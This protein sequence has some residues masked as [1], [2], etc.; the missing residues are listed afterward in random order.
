M[1][2][3]APFVFRGLGFLANLEGIQMVEG[4]EWKNEV[5][6]D[7]RSERRIDLQFQG[8]GAR[9]WFLERRKCLTRGIYNRSVAGNRFSGKQISSWATWRFNALM[10][11]RRYSA[12]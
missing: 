9:P 4:G 8:A 3:G 2:F 11:G 12:N 5:R 6:R 10:S 7:S 1:N